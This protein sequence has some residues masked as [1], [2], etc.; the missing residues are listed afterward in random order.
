MKI[1][2]TPTEF[3]TLILAVE[4]ATSTVRKGL[5]GEQAGWTKDANY[6]RYSNLEAKLKSLRQPAD[7]VSPN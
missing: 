6:L 4:H 7:R 5:Q 2:L 3:H 1:E